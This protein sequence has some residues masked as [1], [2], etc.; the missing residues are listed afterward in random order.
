MIEDHA[1]AHRVPLRFAATKLVEGDAT[2]MDKLEINQNEREIVQ[3]VVDEM[4]AAL[5]TDREAAWRIC[6]TAISSRCAPMR[7][8]S[9]R[10]RWS[11]SVR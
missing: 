7:C 5:G 8:T 3:H 10:R 1:E 4:E 9:P 11:S 6:G 2:M